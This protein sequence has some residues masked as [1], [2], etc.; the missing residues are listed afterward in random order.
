MWDH[1]SW[2]AS[3][4]TT[5]IL[6]VKGIFCTAVYNWWFDL[7]VSWLCNMIPAILWV[8]A[9]RAHRQQYDPWN[10][11]S[12][13]P[14]RNFMD[15]TSFG[16]LINAIKRATLCWISF[17]ISDQY[18][19]TWEPPSGEYPHWRAAAGTGRV[20]SPRQNFRWQNAWGGRNFGWGWYWTWVKLYK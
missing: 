11:R 8:H 16:T 7:K 20:L 17:L 15:G 19:L 14:N 2:L 12:T 4:L 6:V 3:Y 10:D 5:E 1:C 13:L 9:G 18:Q